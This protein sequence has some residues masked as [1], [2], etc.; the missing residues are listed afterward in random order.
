MKPIKIILCLLVNTLLLIVFGCAQQ[1]APTGGPKD[2]DPPVVLKSTPENYATNFN[3]KKITITF[4]EYLDMGNFT[5]ELVVSPPMEEKP[6]IRLRNKQ[7]IIEFEEDLK[8]KVTYTYNFGEGIKDLNEKNVLLNYEFVF[9]TGDYLDSLSVKGTLKNAFDL[10][11]PE[12]PINVMLYRELED[13]IP[14]KQIPYYVGRADKEGNFAVNNLKDGIYKMFVLKDGNSNF[15]FDM[16]DEKIAF[17]D[18]SLTIDG[19]YFR[20]IMLESDVYDSTDLQMKSLT[21]DV[22][23]V[24]MS[25]DSIQILLDSLEQA[26]PDFNALYVDLY[27]FTEESNNQFIS[28]YKRDDKRKIELLF[29]LPLTDSFAFQPVFP[30]TLSMD[31]LIYEFGR[32]RDSLTIWMG[33]TV[34]ADLDTV[35]LSFQ[36]TVYD[37]ID[38]PVSKVDTL[39]FSYRERTTKSRKDD[40]KKVKMESLQISTIRNR[41]KH[42]IR[43]D[44]NFTINEPLLSIEPELF[45]LFIIPDSIEV[46]VEVE[47]FI[48]T[49]HLRR[50]KISHPWKEEGKYRI[51]LYPGAMTNIYGVTNDTTDLTFQIRPLADYGRINLSLENVSDTLIIQLFK[52]DKMTRSLEISTSGTYLFDFIDPA[53][54]H[55]KIVHDRNRNGKWDTGNYLKGLQPEKVE[56]VPRELK[57]RA[58]WDHDVAYIIGTNSDPP[59]SAE[60][61]EDEKEKLLL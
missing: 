8:E 58:N 38:N 11:V 6:E 51:V 35:Q 19:E 16:P 3:A 12:T 13:S 9:S 50:A 24:G 2:E 60:E 39:L 42:D 5:Q 21:I 4:D 7:L 36:Y 29:N 20:K 48:D 43:R 27:M 55:I 30:G 45:G 56:F 32:N 34:V 14:L 46:P 31:D 22:D 52:K 53:T 26:K 37:S 49:T 57:I 41:A 54:Y 40:K 17:L 33:D 44:L 61:D 25:S 28:E 18:S 10:S 59:S 15:L 1:G 23:T 47:P